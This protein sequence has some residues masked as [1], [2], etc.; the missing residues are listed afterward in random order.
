MHRIKCSEIWGGNKETDTDVCAGSLTASLFSSSADGGKGGDIYY[1]G[2]CG[3]ETLT[4]IAVADVVGHGKVVS[5]ISQWL[6]DSMTENMNGADGK[7]VL[8]DL[9]KQAKSHGLKAVTT[10]EVIT[11]NK[12]NFNLTFS[13][14]GHPPLLL[15]RRSENQWRRITVRKSSEG[16]NVPLGIIDHPNYDENSII[17]SEG[18]LLFIYTDGVIETPGSAGGYFGMDGLM[19]VLEKSETNDPKLLK[20]EVLEVIH[21][22][23]GKGFSHD[24]VTLMAIRID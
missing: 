20:Q 11:F 8:D 24:D 9:N 18:D 12:S 22:F 21:N 10:G 14:A 13:N 7:L 6:Y 4:R 17:L 23:S 5:D 3:H 1:L 16:K 19:S 15:K 2:V